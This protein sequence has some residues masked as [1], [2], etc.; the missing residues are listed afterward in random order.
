MLRL[1]YINFLHTHFLLINT[2]L[3]QQMSWLDLLNQC[4]C[5]TVH[6]VPALH[7]VFRVTLAYEMTLGFC[8]DR[9]ISTF[10]DLSTAH[11]VVFALCPWQSCFTATW[12]SVGRITCLIQGWQ[13]LTI[14]QPFAT[15]FIR[16]SLQK[17]ILSFYKFKN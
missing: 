9:N 1:L 7:N 10:A 8:F 2:V 11:C 6:L 3:S 5:Q 17:A 14:S 16:G 12:P 4:I 15:R 13:L